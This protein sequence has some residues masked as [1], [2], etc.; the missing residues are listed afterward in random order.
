MLKGKDTLLCGRAMLPLK[1]EHPTTLTLDIPDEIA[2][3]MT[4]AG[5][6]LHRAALEALA[7]EGYRRGALTQAHVGRLLGLSRIQT[8]DFLAEHADLIDYDPD[9]LSREL[10]ALAGH[11]ETSR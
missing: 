6:E 5:Q 11:S 4:S 8:E 9:E 10:R 2:R 1:S 3:E 7:I